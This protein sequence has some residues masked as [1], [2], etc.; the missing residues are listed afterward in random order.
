MWENV[1]EQQLHGS[2]EAMPQRCGLFLDI[3]FILSIGTL[4]LFIFVLLE[5]MRVRKMSQKQCSLCPGTRTEIPHEV[6]LR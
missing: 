6:Q 3:D 2:F 4:V 1:P 5:Q